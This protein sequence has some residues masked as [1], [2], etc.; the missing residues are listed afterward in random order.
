M[1]IIYIYIYIYYIIYN[2]QFIDIIDIPSFILRN[3]IPSYSIILYV[4]DIPMIFSRPAASALQPFA[5]VHKPSQPM[6][7]CDVS[8][9]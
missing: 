5:L 4:S 6:W 7:Q 8:E 2:V 3:M 9:Q 1:T